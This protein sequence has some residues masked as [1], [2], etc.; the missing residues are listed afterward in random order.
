MTFRKAATEQWPRKRNQ[1]GSPRT[2]RN[3]S[4][5][6]TSIKCSPARLQRPLEDLLQNQPEHRFALKKLA[7]I[8]ATA[9][10]LSA[11]GG[12]GEQP[13]SCSH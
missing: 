11:P 10:I 7:A 9:V 1:L 6:A 12:H 13:R 5:G 4:R 2:R 3:P 8:E